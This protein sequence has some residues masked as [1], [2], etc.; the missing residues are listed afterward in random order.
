MLLHRSCTST[1]S[2]YTLQAGIQDYHSHLA[3]HPVGSSVLRDHRY[4]YYLRPESFPSPLLLFLVLNPARLFS[5]AGRR[6]HAGG[7][8]FPVEG[9]HIHPSQTRHSASNSPAALLRKLCYF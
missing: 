5:C 1:H 6:Y 8:R 3:L 9:A 4:T 7:D 2:V